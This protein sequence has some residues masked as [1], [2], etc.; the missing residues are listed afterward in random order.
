[1][2]CINVKEISNIVLKA[3]NYQIMIQIKKDADYI[4][5]KMV[6]E[7]PIDQLNLDKI[8]TQVNANLEIYSIGY[9][10]LEEYLDRNN[11]KLHKYSFCIIKRNPKIYKNVK[12]EVVKF[13]KMLRVVTESGIVMASKYNQKRYNIVTGELLRVLVNIDDG[14]DINYIKDVILK[15][16][17]HI[18]AKDATYYHNSGGVMTGTPTSRVELYQI[19][20]I[21]ISTSLSP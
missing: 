2:D 6:L 18:D 5:A 20:D 1:M 4:W 9:I 14:Y 10:N 17:P 19:S 3:V 8:R 7:F 11:R 15:N 16:Y 12:D 21:P 13:D